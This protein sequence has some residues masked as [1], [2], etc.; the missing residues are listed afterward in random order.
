[1]TRSEMRRNGMNRHHVCFERMDWMN[2]KIGSFVRTAPGLIIP[3]VIENHNE[4][5]REVEPPKVIH[6]VLGGLVLNKLNELSDRHYTLQNRLVMFDGVT[7]YLRAVGEADRRFYAPE[8]LRLAENF[9]Q[10]REFMYEV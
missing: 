4:L 6:P 9:E 2:S 10:Q 8:A 7:E 1:M 5:H 3:M